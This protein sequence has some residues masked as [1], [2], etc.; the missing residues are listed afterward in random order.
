MTT[1]EHC[2]ETLKRVGDK[3]ARKSLPGIEY[4]KNGLL[5]AIRIALKDINNRAAL[6]NYLEKLVIFWSAFQAWRR[7]QAA[8]RAISGWLPETNY[9]FEGF[10]YGCK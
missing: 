2:K 3:L 7:R 8:I 10:K 4:Q 6:E 9:K 5:S 1:A